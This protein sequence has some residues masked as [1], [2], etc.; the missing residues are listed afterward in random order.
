MTL[1]WNLLNM[2]K[3]KTPTIARKPLP[4]SF[5]S[6]T[7]STI[8][9]SSRQNLDSFVRLSSTSTS[10]TN[11]PPPQLPLSDLL[12]QSPQAQESYSSYP[13]PYNPAFVD[14]KRKSLPTS[15]SPSQL[16][17]QISS[18]S[19]TTIEKHQS[20]A[21]TTKI[22]Q[23]ELANNLK[24]QDASESYDLGQPSENAYTNAYFA[25]SDSET[26]KRKSMH[27]GTPQFDFGFEQQSPRIFYKARKFGLPYTSV[28]SGSIRNSLGA[29][30]LQ[31]HNESESHLLSPEFVD[32]MQ[33]GNTLL[34]YGTPDHYSNYIPFWQK[35]WLLYVLF[36][37]AIIGA[38]GHHLFY[39]GLNNKEAKEQTKMLRY[40]SVISFLVKAALSSTAILAFKQRVWVTVRR[41]MLSVN[42]IDNL[43]AATEDL[44]ALANTEIF[45]KAKTAMLLAVFIWSTPLVV[46][47]TSETLS[48]E[49][50]NHVVY[51]TCPGVRTL[52]FTHERNVDWRGGIK[53]DG[54]WALSPVS[55]N[56]T[57]TVELGGLNTT[58]QWN[59]TQASFDY[60]TGKSVQFEQLGSMSLFFGEPLTRANAS[61][62]ICG[63]GWNC[64]FQIQFE[65]PGYQCHEVA[66][67]VD[68]EVG[69]VNG[70]KSPITLD[71]LAPK[72]PYAFRSHTFKGN[73]ENPQ[74][75]NTSVDTGGIIGKGEPMRGI[76]NQT[77]E[78]PKL[79]GS[80]R[81][82]PVIWI[83]YVVTDTS[84][85]EAS[86]PRTRQDAGWDT[87]FTPKIMGCEHMRTRYNATFAYRNTVQTVRITHR[88]HLSRIINTTFID[89]DADFSADFLNDNTTAMP[90][91]NYVYP[92]DIHQYREVAAYHAMGLLFRE[93]LNDS[94]NY[95]S[96]QA[97]GK[98]LTTRLID[99]KEYTAVPD[100]MLE[101]PRVYEEMILSLLQNPLF[102]AVSWAAEPSMRSGLGMGDEP[103]LAWSCQR[104]RL[105]N[106]F[107]YSAVDL[108]LVY[109]IAILLAACAVTFGQ[110]AVIEND[111]VVRDTRFSSIVAATRGPH[112][113]GVDW[114]LKDGRVTRDSKHIRVGYGIVHETDATG[115]GIYGTSGYGF[116]RRKTM[117]DLQS[118]HCSSR[119]G[120]LDSPSLQGVTVP[121]FGFGVDGGVRQSQRLRRFAFKNAGNLIGR[122]FLRKGD[123]G[124]SVS[125]EDWRDMRQTQVGTARS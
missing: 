22:H 14:L 34:P 103:E 122:T 5:F 120:E 65:G 67:G 114:T 101:V 29:I 82:E 125:D 7:V 43:F 77:G 104:S 86:R 17:P 74:V 28:P 6:S 13:S 89:D 90:E 85:P 60:F 88:E 27:D 35:E 9:T 56:T 59:P 24:Q 115:L 21:S 97:F 23:V 51:E 73:Y 47:L 49:V 32:Q 71:E 93:Y 81:T 108:W 64:S 62:E 3:Q 41:K 107:V 113:D 98:V 10:P 2:P 39:A 111:G 102:M 91:E 83:G 46:I 117:L 53:I 45:W 36:F 38:I 42:A 87:F 40:G 72:G 25:V 92:I 68:A 78:W 48:V 96:K 37:L 121:L 106:V 16:P 15:R 124:R 116:D 54:Q 80:F 63:M 11:S 95:E 118:S 44:S 19:A 50:K 58:T 99:H 105:D 109:G 94:I 33:R 123:S 30:S 12:Q 52:N 70:A 4:S 75:L 69:T 79:L 18:C 112:L 61:N 1:D 20:S 110:L 100:F 119:G 76:R 31:K 84:V 26:P 8:A 57:D 55:W 66:S